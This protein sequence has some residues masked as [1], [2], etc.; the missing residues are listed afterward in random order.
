MS[1]VQS[2]VLGLAGQGFN[3]AQ[4][5]LRLGLELTGEENPGLLRVVHGLGHGLGHSG[6]LCGALLGGVCLL[7]WHG[8]RG[9][10]SENAHP[11]LDAMVADLVTWF[12]ESACAPFGASR[13]RASSGGIRC[14]EI[15]HDAGGKP[16]LE[17][18]GGLTGG[19]Y[20]KA[21]AI[22]GEYGLDPTQPPER[23]HA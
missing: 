3:C 6:E 9:E 17:R 2:S 12:R 15:L 11:M 8:G 13:D 1:D 4:I 22:L 20:E 14:A 5:V 23:R 21:L 7:S 19:V 18:C 16:H 10:P